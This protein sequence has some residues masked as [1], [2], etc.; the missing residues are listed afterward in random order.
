MSVLEDSHCL[1]HA[2]VRSEAADDVWSSAMVVVLLLM[3]FRRAACRE[4]RE[5]SLL[6]IPRMERLRTLRTS[7][8]F[9]VPLPATETKANSMVHVVLV[10]GREGRGAGESSGND[11]GSPVH[12]P[13]ED[14]C[15]GAT[16][17]TTASTMLGLARSLFIGSG[18]GGRLKGLLWS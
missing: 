14:P 7:V 8:D 13:V 3:H 1:W 5:S 18:Q 9:V 11:V 15:R 12:H 17:P 4:R 2:K 6:L 10:S 16:N